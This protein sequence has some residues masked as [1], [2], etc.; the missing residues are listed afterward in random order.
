MTYGKPDQTAFPSRFRYILVSIPHSQPPRTCY[1][2][3]TANPPCRR[4]PLPVLHQPPRST[5]SAPCLAHSTGPPPAAPTA[6]TPTSTA[7]ILTST[8]ARPTPHTLAARATI[9]TPTPT[10]SH[11]GLRPGLHP[12]TA[13]PALHGLPGSVTM[14]LCRALILG[15]IAAACFLQ[16]TQSTTGLSLIPGVLALHSLAGSMTTV[17]QC[18]PADLDLFLGKPLQTAR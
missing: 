1:N 3:P 13:V 9:P 5:G 16:E 18:C 2:H 14:L 17:L 15:H 6:Y 10:G 7:P 8:H 4:A 11:S 12:S